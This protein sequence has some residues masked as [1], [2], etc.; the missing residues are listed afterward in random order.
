MI[1]S[2][3]TNPA[4]A[5][6]KKTGGNRGVAN[7][8]ELLND[9][10]GTRPIWIRCPKGSGTEYWSGFTRSYLYKLAAEGKIRSVSIRG[11][12]GQVKGVRLFHLQSILDCVATFEAAASAGNQTTGGTIL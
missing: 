8:A 5:S 12:P 11:K 4:T 6:G 1:D 9:R 2:Y 3:G 7:L 10:D